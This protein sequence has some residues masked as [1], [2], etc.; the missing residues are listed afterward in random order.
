MTTYAERLSL[1]SD[2]DGAIQLVTERVRAVVR[3]SGVHSG[4]AHLLYQH[5]TGALLI[6]EYEAG[7]L[8]D[9]EDALERMAPID[10]EYLHHRRGFDRN[11]AAHVRTALLHVSL[12]V[13]VLDGDLALGAWQEI[14][15]ADF[16]PG[17]KTRTLLVHVMGDAQ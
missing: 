17:C 13:P 15:V 11:G 9:W 5:T 4:V 3:A 8:A 12:S 10:Q 16:D 1:L 2:G 6:V 7:I 14:V